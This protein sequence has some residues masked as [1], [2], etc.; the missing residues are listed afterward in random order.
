[1]RPVDFYAIIAPPRYAIPSD[2][3]CKRHAILRIRY[4]LWDERE[5]SPN[6]L[7]VALAKLSRRHP[8]EGNEFLFKVEL[9]K[10]LLRFS[11]RSLDAPQDTLSLV[12]EETSSRSNQDFAAYEQE[13][14]MRIRQA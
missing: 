14:V 4:A 2:W 9:H 6:K 12:F 8:A 1:L 11:V 13:I 7:G 3:A 5:T 10:N